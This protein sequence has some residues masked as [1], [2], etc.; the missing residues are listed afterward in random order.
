MIHS[1]L[2]AKYPT[3]PIVEQRKGLTK[4]ASL[5]MINNGESPIVINYVLQRIT[6]LGENGDY[7]GGYRWDGGSDKVAGGWTPQ[8]PTDAQILMHCFCALLDEY[9]P[10]FS[11]TYFKD[12]SQANSSSSSTS[13]SS[14]SASSSSS[15][16][17]SKEEDKKESWRGLKIVQ[18][19]TSPRAPYYKLAHP[20]AHIDWRPEPGRSNLFHTLVLFVFYVKKHLKGQVG[21]IQLSDYAIN[22]LGLVIS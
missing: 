14:A 3:H 16:R 6:E 17:A 19:R 20:A 10:G 22:R 9:D 21:L 2:C 12:L 11:K 7:L 1:F 8:F 18:T 15:S 13:S 5:P 4:F